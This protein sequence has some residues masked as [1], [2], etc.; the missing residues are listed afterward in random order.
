MGQAA[1]GGASGSSIGN[2]VF[3]GTAD[4]IKGYGEQGSQEFLAAR[5]ERAAELGRLRAS[6]TDTQLR[7]ELNTTLANIDAIRAAANI[8]PLSP[9]TG[10]IKAEE[11]RVSDRARRIKVAGIEAQAREDEL[12]AGYRRELGEQ[13]QVLGFL[14]A[15]AKGLGPGALLAGKLIGG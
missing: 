14:G 4:I 12:S 10:V 8:D 9:T 11:A 5:D 13:A 1:A 15:A 7:E 6:Q 3:G 2:A